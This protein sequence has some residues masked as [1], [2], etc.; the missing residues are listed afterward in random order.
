MGGLQKGRLVCVGYRNL[1]RFARSRAGLLLGQKNCLDVREN[2]T[3]SDGHTVEELVQFLVI[4]DGQLQVT[5]DDTRLLVVLGRVPGELKDLSGQVLKNGR[6]VHGGTGT[7]ALSVV[8][9]ADES[10]DT[11]HGELK[12]RPAGAGLRLATNLTTLSLAFA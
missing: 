8:T 7:N 3:L 1:L 5:R 2:T 10:V 6:Q 9:L 11:A 12:S 4:T